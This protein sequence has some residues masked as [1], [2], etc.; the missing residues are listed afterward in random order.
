MDTA[1]ACLLKREPD[2]MLGILPQNDREVGVIVPDLD[3]S[4]VKRGSWGGKETPRTEGGRYGEGTVLV[5][6][7]IAVRHDI[8]FLLQKKILIVDDLNTSSG[9]GLAEMS[10]PLDVM[11]SLPKGARGDPN[12]RF[13]N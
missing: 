2:C 5:S 10:A 8:F 4:G 13:V 1:R 11:I 9:E 3:W 6:E 12:A 7:C